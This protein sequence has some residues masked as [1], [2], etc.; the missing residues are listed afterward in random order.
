MNGRLCKAFMKINA[1]MPATQSAKKS[2]P[3]LQTPASTAIA[4][5]IH[6]TAMWVFAMHFNPHC[7]AAKRIFNFIIFY[8]IYYISNKIE[9]KF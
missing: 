2:L 9:T 4:A 7:I 8:S 5:T 6:A 3:L 1:H